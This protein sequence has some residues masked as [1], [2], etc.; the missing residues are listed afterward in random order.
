MLGVCAIQPELGLQRNAVGQS[1]FDTLLDGIPGRIDEVIQEFEHKVVARIGDGEV[2][3][4]YLVQAFVMPVV[5]SRL[6]LEKIPERFQLDIEEIG[7]VDLVLA[8]SEV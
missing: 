7:I 4:E 6:K 1:P 5:R 2:L 8:D 3:T